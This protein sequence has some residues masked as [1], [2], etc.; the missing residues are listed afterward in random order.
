MAEIEPARADHYEGQSSW[1]LKWDFT[2]QIIE[3]QS[4]IVTFGLVLEYYC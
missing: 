4:R 3:L 2:W 1:K